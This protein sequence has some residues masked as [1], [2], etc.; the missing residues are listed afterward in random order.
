M[1]VHV[2]ELTSDV[3]VEPGPASGPDSQETSDAPTR[4]Q[5][6]ERYRA[7]HE[8]VMRDLERV[9]AEGYGD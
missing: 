2:D 3:R 9:S 6:D 1:S 5:Q 7:V 8:R 4:W